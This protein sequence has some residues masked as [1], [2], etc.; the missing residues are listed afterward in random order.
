MDAVLAVRPS[1]TCDLDDLFSRMKAL[2]Q[3]TTKPEFDPLIIGFKRA[4]RIVQKEQWT[5]NRIQSERFEHETEHI[6]YT[7]VGEVQRVIIGVP[8]KKGIW[9]GV[10]GPHWV[11]ISH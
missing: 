6:L 5:D 3:I 8:G 10:E 11:K 9:G 4:H 2:E 1:G 7:A